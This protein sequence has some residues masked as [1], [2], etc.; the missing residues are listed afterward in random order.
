VKDPEEF[1][2]PQPLEP[3]QLI[4][5]RLCRTS[6]GQLPL[7]QQRNPKTISAFFPHHASNQKLTTIHHKLTTKKP[8]KKLTTPNKIATCTIVNIYSGKARIQIDTTPFP[9]GESTSTASILIEIMSTSTLSSSISADEF[10]ALEQK[11]LRAV[12][13]VKRER[14][15]R[16]AAEAEVASLR[17]QLAVFE[18]NTRAVESELA[19]LNKE[20]DQVRLRVEKMLEQMDELL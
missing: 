14:E 17:E 19:T 2:S 3:F 6:A 13:I 8:H 11:V 7:G 15:A 5:S 12:E 18:S 1:H 9:S 20:R 10:Q 4:T 16:A